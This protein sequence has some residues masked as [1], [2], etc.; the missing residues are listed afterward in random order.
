MKKLKR[1]LCLCLLLALLAC[2]FAACGGNNDKKPSDSS[3]GVEEPSD[4]DPSDGKESEKPIVKHSIKIMSYNLDQ[5]NGNSTTQR[6]AVLGS[7]TNELPD[8]IGVQEETY[9]WRDFLT[10]EL[11]VEGYAHVFK[12]RGN[13]P[14]DEASGIFYNFDRFTLKDSG[15]F[16]LSDTPDDQSI[17]ANWG[18]LYPRVCTWVL[19]TDKKTGKDFAYF[20]SHFSYVNE[21][22]RTKSSQLV[23]SRIEAL[24]VPAFFSGDLN[25]ASDRE[26]GTYGVLTEKLDDSRTQAQNTDSGCTFHDYGRKSGELDSGGVNTIA[27]VPI[28][29][30]FCTKGD[31]TATDFNILQ[32]SGPIYSSD[33]F[34]ITACFDYN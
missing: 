5:A 25:F 3:T 24:G 20:N 32:E 12:F 13:P 26:V 23:L 11:E 8:L 30:I 14:Y 1:L 7:I 9:A 10:N 31:F 29:Y 15:T 17:A 6:A 27:Y 34:A 2:C 33:H 22:V 4:D 21:N 28:D 18:A 19:L 16:W